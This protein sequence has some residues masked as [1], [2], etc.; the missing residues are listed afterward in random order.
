MELFLQKNTGKQST[1]GR[2]KGRNAGSIAGTY[3]FDRSQVT[4]HADRPS[5]H[6]GNN[7]DKAMSG[8]AGF[9]QLT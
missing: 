6:C 9:F 5:Q 3:V 1:E 2:I 8:T 4:C 7:D